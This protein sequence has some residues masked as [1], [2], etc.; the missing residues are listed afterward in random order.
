M[1]KAPKEP[2]WIEWNLCMAVK[3]D[4]GCLGFGNVKM[5]FELGLFFRDDS[6][7]IY[8]VAVPVHGAALLKAVLREVASG[9]IVGCFVA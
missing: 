3:L 1:A 6:R 9:I 8:I 7:P 5:V 2:S 4:A